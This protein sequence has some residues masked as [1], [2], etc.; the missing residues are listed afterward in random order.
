VRGPLK[1]SVTLEPLT[2]VFFFHVGVR[3]MMMRWR[4]ITSHKCLAGVASLGGGAG[5]V[6]PVL[7]SFL[8]SRIHPEIRNN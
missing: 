3:R 4:G 5:H 1:R 7:A 6:L 2:L 8:P